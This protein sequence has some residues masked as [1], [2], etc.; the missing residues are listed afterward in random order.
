MARLPNLHAAYAVQTDTDEGLPYAAQHT[1]FLGGGDRITAILRSVEG[2]HSPRRNSNA[3]RVPMELDAVEDDFAEGNASDEAMELDPR[4]S[5]HPRPRGRQGY[6]FVE[7]AVE[8]GEIR[9]EDPAQQQQVPE[10][11]ADPAQQ[12]QVPGQSEYKTCGGCDKSGHEL[13]TC[14]CTDE[15][16]FVPGCVF[17][18]VAEH[19][20]VNCQ[21][22]PADLNGRFKVLVEDRQKMPP[23]ADADWFSIFIDYRTVN[24]RSPVSMDAC[25]REDILGRSPLLASQ[26]Q[27]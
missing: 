13:A 26:S 12:Q 3:G 19:Q 11:P 1:R 18:N 17:C 14:I 23:L 8:S 16:G 7:D 5:P 15:D 20:T 9:P 2:R 21:R 10:P 27:A 25:L 22:Y 24:F 6:G 4:V